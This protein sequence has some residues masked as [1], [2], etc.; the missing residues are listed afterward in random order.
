[1]IGNL[2]R[3]HNLFCWNLNDLA[4]TIYSY[5]LQEFSKGIRFSFELEDS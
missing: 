1:M 5:L 2:I 3:Q 4:G